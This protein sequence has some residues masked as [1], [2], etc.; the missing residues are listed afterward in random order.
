[1]NLPNPVLDRF[2]LDGRVAVVTGASSGLG[3]GFA[4]ALAHAGADEDVRIAAAD[5]RAPGAGVRVLIAAQGR[6]YGLVEKR[7]TDLGKVDG[8]DLEGAVRG[9]EFAEPARPRDRHD[10]AGCF[11]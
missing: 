5:N 10:L 6:M 1:V 9:G 4:L 11:R 3:A 7:E 2:R 8:L